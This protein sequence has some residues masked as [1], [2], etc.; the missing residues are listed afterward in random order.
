MSY[1][2]IVNLKSLPE[3]ALKLREIVLGLKSA[4]EAL[5]NPPNLFQVVDECDNLGSVTAIEEWSSL[6]D[7]EIYEQ[8]ADRIALVGRLKEVLIAP[9]DIRRFN[10]V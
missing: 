3:D 1:W 10:A 5:T 8:S 6:A 7:E 2:V 9:P 4:A